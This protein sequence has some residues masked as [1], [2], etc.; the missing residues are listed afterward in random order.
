MHAAY[1]LAQGRPRAWRG[2]K[3]HWSL[4][5]SDRHRKDLTNAAPPHFRRARTGIRAVTMVR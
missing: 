5:V 3:Q 1:L 4:R 2:L